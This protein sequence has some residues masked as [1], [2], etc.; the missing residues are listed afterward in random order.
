MVGSNSVYGY[1]FPVDI[2]VGIYQVTSGGLPGAQLFSQTFTP[3]QYQ[4]A[5]GFYGGY[6][7]RD[8]RY[9]GSSDYRALTDVISIIQRPDS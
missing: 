1:T 6:Q 3:A 5:S 7:P 9:E 8:R 2:T 4:F